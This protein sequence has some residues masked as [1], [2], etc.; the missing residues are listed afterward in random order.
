[1]LH[2]II[3]KVESLSNTYIRMDNT[4]VTRENKDIIR[5]TINTKKYIQVINK[6]VDIEFI[7]DI[8]SLMK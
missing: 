2:F 6:E 1:M 8:I 3:I 5:E 7:N 4:K